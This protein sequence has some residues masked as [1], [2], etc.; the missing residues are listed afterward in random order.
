MY[1]SMATAVENFWEMYTIGFLKTSGR[2]VA[3][4][5]A[6]KLLHALVSR[7][8]RRI[9]K[10][11]EGSKDYAIQLRRAQTLKPLLL[12]IE[13]YVIYFLVAVTVLAQVGI[14]TGAILASVGVVGIALGFGAQNLVKDMIAGFFLLFDGLVAAGDIV[15]VDDNTVGAVEAV[16]LRNTQVRDFSGLLWIIPNGDL[17]QFGNFNR[18]WMRAVVPIQLAFEEDVEHAKATVLEVAEA[19]A[20]ENKDLVLEPPEVQGLMAIGDTS[21]G[22]RLVVKMKA[23][24][25]WAAERELRARIKHAFDGKGIEIP[26]PRRVVYEKPKNVVRPDRGVA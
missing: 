20:L 21:M 23:M 15:K 1:E 8:T 6:G 11:R 14:D 24:E 12:E 25:Q 10:P 4:L 2:I 7:L 9:L 16:G 22:L 3:I 19:W 17:R 5:I 13:R 26:Y 18:G